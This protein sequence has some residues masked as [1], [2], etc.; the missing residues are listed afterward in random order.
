M[1]LFNIII[2]KS[3]I[4]LDCFTDRFDVLQYSPIQYGNKHFPEWWKKTPPSE[5][6]VIPNGITSE[7]STIK[8]C[9]GIID[10]Y[11]NSIAMPLWS[12]VKINIGTNKEE[13]VQ[14]LFSDP[15]SKFVEHHQSQWRTF[16]DPAIYA[17]LKFASPWLFNTK[18]DLNF[19]YVGN[20]YANDNFMD[21]NIPSAVLNFKYQ[22]GTDINII[23]K[24]GS[25]KRTIDFK[26]NDIMYNLFP[27][28]ESEVIIHNHYDVDK[29]SKLSAVGGTLRTF[30]QKYRKNKKILSQKECPY[31]LIRK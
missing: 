25:V 10:F 11:K 9:S 27:L 2:R 26:V 16:I 17:P 14:W 30:I 28:T 20:P 19:L 18:E 29:Y 13:G 3:K 4:H 15:E 5:T 24:Y 23:F 6:M 31:H 21:Y 8:R 22:F 1:K 7:F 12:D